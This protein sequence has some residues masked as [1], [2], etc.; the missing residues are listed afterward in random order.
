MKQHPYI[1][2]A[3]IIVL[4]FVIFTAVFIWPT[5]YRYERSY[6]TVVRINRFTGN[7]EMLTTEGWDKMQ[8]SP[9]GNYLT[10]EQAK[11]LGLEDK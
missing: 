8:S 3:A 2:I 10:P 9:T 6:Q 1:V 7:A 4:L 5:L 11:E